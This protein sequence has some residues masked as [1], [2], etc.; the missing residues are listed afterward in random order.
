M[1]IIFPPISSQPSTHPGKNARQSPRP[2]CQNPTQAGNFWVFLP[3]HT[4]R[5]VPLLIWTCLPVSPST[6]DSSSYFKTTS[7]RKELIQNCSSITTILFRQDLRSRAMVRFHRPHPCCPPKL[8]NHLTFRYHSVAPG[9]LEVDWTSTGMPGRQGSGRL[10]VK[11]D[12]S[13]QPESGFIILLE[14]K[15]RI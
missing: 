3:P 14:D 11:H 13:G 2:S 6:T 5:F 9:Q 4:F 15:W 12:T 7:G 8:D 10:C 1:P